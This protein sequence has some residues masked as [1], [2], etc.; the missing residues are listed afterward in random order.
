MESHESKIIKQ[1]LSAV[2]TTGKSDGL[3]NVTG[4]LKAL[5]KV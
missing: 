1:K 4:R 3:L 5:L 2:I